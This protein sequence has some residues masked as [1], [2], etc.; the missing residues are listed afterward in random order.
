[1]KPK[2]PLAEAPKIHIKDI[3]MSSPPA[4]KADD[5]VATR[6]AYGT[7]LKKIADTNMRWEFLYYEKWYK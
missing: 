2:P 4:Y 3:I 7:A 6:L 1:M 5:L